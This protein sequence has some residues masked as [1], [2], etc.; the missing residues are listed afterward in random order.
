M[1]PDN[2]EDDDEFVEVTVPTEL[3]R[4]VIAAISDVMMQWESEC[5]DKNEEFN[6]LIG[7]S[8]VHMAMRFI[9]TCMERMP[10]ETVQ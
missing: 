7:T 9:D 8:A 4:R 6:A 2:W 5:R 3:V 10:E 1:E